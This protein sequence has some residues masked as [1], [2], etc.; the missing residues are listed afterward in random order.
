MCSRF[1][2][3][4]GAVVM[5]ATMLL[6]VA[7]VGCARPKGILFEPIDPPR[8]W[9]APPEQARI[10]LI[11]AISDSEDL[12]AA[13]SGGEV[14]MGVLRGPRP[15]IRLSGPHSVAIREPNVLA[16]ADTKLAAAHVIDLEERTH[17]TVYGWDE[18]R[19][20]SPVGVTWCGRRLFVT[21]AKRH[22]V[23]ELDDQG[24]F[25]NR[26]GEDDLV[27][28]VGI[29][30]V[31]Q[32]KQLYVVDGGA[33]QLKVFELDGRMIAAV[34]GPGTEPGRFNY[35]THLCASG[36]RLLVADSGNFRVQI[37]DLDGGSIGVFGQKGDGAGDFALP[38][39][40]AFDSDGHVYVVD[41]HFENVQ[42]FD[43]E[44]QLLLAFGQEGRKLGRFW[45]PAG[46][47]IDSKDR[48]WVADSGNRRLQVFEYLRSAS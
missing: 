39:G 44:G 33:H 6:T 28:P 16:V 9:P 45:L 21:D 17:L 31:P 32:R 13:K 43:S 20:A 18:E 5:S 2:D 24:K 30:Y 1:A 36:G 29:A 19:L 7:M 4:W 15:P 10:R 23:I 35:P 25:R 12:K 47:A 42:V 37:L 22:E 34:G 11:G 41:A 27:R 48:I 40:V 3:R 38:K 8:V 14:L 46:L 26:F